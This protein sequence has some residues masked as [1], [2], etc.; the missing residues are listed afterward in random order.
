MGGRAIQITACMFDSIPILLIDKAVHNERAQLA[1]YI[2][3]NVARTLCSQD[4]GETVFAPLFR[5]KPEGIQAH[6][7]VLVTDRSP[8]ELM[9]LIKKRYDW[10]FSETAFPRDTQEIS[11]YDVEQELARRVFKPDLFE[12]N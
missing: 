2:L 8:Q 11:T 7:S 10:S 3:R 1:Q 6:T 4:T 12:G 9:G 5:D